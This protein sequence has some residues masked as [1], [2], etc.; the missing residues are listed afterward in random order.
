MKKY[1]KILIFILIL[2]VGIFLNRRFQLGSYLANVDNFERISKFVD[3]N[4]IL[5][6]SLYLIFTILGSSILA[7]PGVTFA[8]VGSGL[9]GPWLG[10]FYCL[11]G[12]TIGALFS[13]LLSRYFLRDYIK[14]LVKKNKKLY[15]IIFK[16]DSDREILILMIT[17]LLP[18]FPFNL[19]NFAYGITDISTVKYTL[20][21]FVFMIPGI[22]IFSIGTNGLINRNNRINMLIIGLL[23]LFFIII[24]GIFL[25][26]KY[27]KLITE[28]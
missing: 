18:I 21:S 20:G 3:K 9:F 5:S 17:R 8:I 25:Y 26:K 7:L 2:T 4:H 23:I 16:M 24:I 28:G 22:I 27:R 6:M 12:T 15:D 19:Q 14:E 13:F 1:G 10:S 11:I